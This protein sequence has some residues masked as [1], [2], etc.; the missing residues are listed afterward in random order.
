MTVSVINS[1][2]LS[3]LVSYLAKNYQT[4]A[5]QEENG[6]VVIGELVDSKKAI[7][8]SRLSFYSWKRFFVPECEVLF[9]YDNKKLTSG[10][11]PAGSE[12]NKKEVVLFGL[13]LL[14]LKYV[15]LYDR[16]FF[17]D[18]YYQSR[19]NNL[20]IIAHNFLP[21]PENNLAHVEYNRENLNRFS[22]DVFLEFGRDRYL[23]LVSWSKNLDSRWSLSRSGIRGGNGKKDSLMIF[24]GSERGEKLLQ[25]TGYKD[26][27]RIECLGSLNEDRLGS[28][29]NIFRDKLKNHHN[30]KIW[31]ELGKRCIECGKCTIVC[32]TCFCFRMDDTPSLEVGRGQRQRC[33]DTCFYQ[34]FSEISGGYQFLKNTAERIHFWYYHKFA[35]IPDE[36]S[37]TGCVGCHRCYQVC[38]VEIDIK[39]TLQDIEKS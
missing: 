13:N 15:L 2:Q 14:D 18:P 34:E 38:P 20:L 39:Q 5:T 33:W 23:E 1:R 7:L 22:F 32:P 29:M 9:D 21:G 3:K 27:Q 17:I 24:A 36:Y 35:R 19:R 30:P 11:R 10:T 31:E 25:K 12:N 6:Q 28:K 26:Y 16:V 37:I 8:D 4:Y